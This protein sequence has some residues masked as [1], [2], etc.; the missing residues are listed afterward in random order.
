[1]AVAR[2]FWKGGSPTLTA[3]WRGR[4]QTWQLLRVEDVTI[5]IVGRGKGICWAVL[6]GTYMLLLCLQS[7]G[8]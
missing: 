5:V 8:F 2:D 1:M 6:R 4:P 3:F 7:K